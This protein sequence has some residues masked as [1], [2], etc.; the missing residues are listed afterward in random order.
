M[1]PPTQPYLYLPLY[2][3]YLLLTTHDPSFKTKS[4]PENQNQKTKMPASVI[5]FVFFKIRPDVKPEDPKS[6]EDGESLLKLFNDTRLQHGY[7][8]GAWGRTIEDT[9]FI[10]WVICMFSS[11]AFFG[12]YAYLSISMSRFFG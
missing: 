5:E 11:F 12:F 4:N 10:V 8:A 9:D 6:N 2:Y 7:L 1:Y 3:I